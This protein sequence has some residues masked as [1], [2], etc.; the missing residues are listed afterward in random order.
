MILELVLG[1]GL[2]AASAAAIALALRTGQ[3]KAEAG[4]LTIERDAALAA[5]KV[6]HGESLKYRRLIADQAKRLRS[7]R[8]EL[9]TCGDPKVRGR[10]AVAG[11]R[12]LL[13][14]LPETDNAPADP[15]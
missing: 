7:A 8:D 10:L 11:I 2:V 15:G 14:A 12:G 9:E 1:G 13:Q 3:L 6:A 4:A 5:V